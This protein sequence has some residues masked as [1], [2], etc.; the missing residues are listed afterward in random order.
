MTAR[1]MRI[2]GRLSEHFSDAALH[3]FSALAFNG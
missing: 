3:M 1:S 2:M